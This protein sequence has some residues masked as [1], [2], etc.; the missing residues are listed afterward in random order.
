MFIQTEISSLFL[1]D[2]R[3]PMVKHSLN[4]SKKQKVKRV[5]KK[6]PDH[7]EEGGEEEI[8]IVGTSLHTRGLS[9]L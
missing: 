9:R 3:N 8:F 7:G 6:S 1:G 5:V 2:A 4:K